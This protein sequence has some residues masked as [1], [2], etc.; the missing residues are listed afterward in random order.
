MLSINSCKVLKG[1]REKCL[2]RYLTKVFKLL[3]GVSTSVELKLLI[4]FVLCISESIQQLAILQILERE[5][6]RERELL[7]YYASV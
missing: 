6:E 2:R 4:F 7:V 5:R 1:E 3:Q